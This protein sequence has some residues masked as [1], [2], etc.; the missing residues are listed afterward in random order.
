MG[1]AGLADIGFADPDLRALMDTLRPRFEREPFGPMEF[2]V[3]ELRR[4]GVFAYGVVQPQCP[5]GAPIR[6]RDTNFR[7][8][9]NP[10]DW[11][12]GR[13]YVLWRRQP[14][15]SKVAVLA[16]NPTDVVWIE[17]ERQHRLPRRLFNME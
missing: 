9:L 8:Q 4:S 13:T 10:H 15:G 17:W 5:G 12:G 16:V 3:R 14:E 2:A 1:T 11:F 6:W 7:D